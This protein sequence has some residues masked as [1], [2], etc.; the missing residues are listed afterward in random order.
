[1][2]PLFFAAYSPV[3]KRLGLFLVALMVVGCAANP[4]NTQPPEPASQPQQLSVR[5]TLQRERDA[6][7]DAGSTESDRPRVETLRAERSIA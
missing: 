7:A 5:D 3:K 1:M 2:L 6:A 4:S